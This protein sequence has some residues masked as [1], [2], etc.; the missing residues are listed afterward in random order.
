MVLSEIEV[1]YFKISKNDEAENYEKIL[2]A[3]L[4]FIASVAEVQ[5]IQRQT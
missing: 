5:L 3:P 2:S 1:A 4:I